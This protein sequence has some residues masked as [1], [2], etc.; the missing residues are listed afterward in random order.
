M[1]AGATRA[2][3]ETPAIEILAPIQRAAAGGTLHSVHPGS[4]VPGGYT[5]SFS[6][7]APRIWR[8]LGRQGLN[9]ADTAWDDSRLDVRKAKSH[10]PA[11]RA[12][13]GLSDSPA[14]DLCKLSLTACR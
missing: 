4:A 5:E 7:K 1:H 3:L 14:S 11:L 8:N 2:A 9:G 10:N 13:G 6:V 12:A